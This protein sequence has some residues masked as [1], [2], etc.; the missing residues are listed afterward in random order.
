[1]VSGFAFGQKIEYK[2]GQVSVDK[3]PVARIT[4]ARN[5]AGLPLVKDYFAANLE[6][7]PLFSAVFSD[8]IPEDPNDNTVFYFEFRFEG[9][10]SP[11]YLPVS[12]L[13]GDK[14]IANYIGKFALVNNQT[15]D[16]NAVRTLVQ[17]KGK[18]PPYRL[19]YDMTSR[20]RQF[21]VEIRE[22]GRISQAGTEIGTFSQ[23]SSDGN[24]AT[25]VFNSPGGIRM[26]TAVFSGGNNA[27]SVEVCHPARQRE[28]H[29]GRPRRRC[30]HARGC[31]P[32]LCDSEKNCGVARPER[33][34][35]GYQSG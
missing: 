3:Q 1:M 29:D 9:L 5:S 18:T 22:A 27:R 31:G 19:N 10:E 32:Q 17:Q 28:A 8:L 33:V 4:S 30:D 24:S 20:N 15:L 34:F 7:Q 23:V 25:Y 16:L 6:G 13:G 12:K 11:A 2:E 35:V 21:P 14:T 26:A